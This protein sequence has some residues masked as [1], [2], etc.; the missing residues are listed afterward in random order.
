[1]HILTAMYHQHHGTLQTSEIGINPYENPD[2]IGLARTVGLYAFLNAVSAQVHAHAHQLTAMLM[3]FEKESHE[4]GYPDLL[5]AVIAQLAIISPSLPVLQD[6]LIKN[7]EVLHAFNA[8]RSIINTQRL[9]VMLRACEY[10]EGNLIYD[11]HKKLIS[12]LDRSLTKN[13]FIPL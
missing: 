13:V 5:T 6:D 1:M 3:Q 11:F 4:L 8:N 7:F 9:L 2:F 10:Q 12:V